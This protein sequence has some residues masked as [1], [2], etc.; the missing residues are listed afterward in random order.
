MFNINFLFHCKHTAVEDWPHR[1]T[2]PQWAATPTFTPARGDPH[3]RAGRTLAART[4]GEAG[5]G[6][7]WKETLYRYSLIGDW[8]TVCYRLTSFGKVR[9]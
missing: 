4:R 9:F 6:Q 8:S 2:V 3:R 5:A 1:H 7:R